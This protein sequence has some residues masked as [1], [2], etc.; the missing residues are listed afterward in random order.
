MRS[1]CTAP[2]LTAHQIWDSATRCTISNLQFQAVEAMDV[3]KT[4]HTEITDRISELVA[5]GKLP[6][7]VRDGTFTVEQ[8]K[9]PDHADLATNAA[10]VLAKPARMKPR[11]IAE[12]LVERLE[13]H[14]GIERAEI[15]G[16]GFVN[17]DLT[18]S[19]WQ[20]VFSNVLDSAANYGKSGVGQ[21]IKTNVEYVSANPTGP[22]HVGHCRGAVFGD[23]LANLLEFA[24][25][26]VT[27][28]F[29]VNDAGGQ[30]DVLAQSTFLRYRE[31][32]GEEIGAIP[33]G[34]YPGTYLIPVGQQLAETHGDA[35]IGMSEENW[36]PI[37]KRASIDAMLARIR[38]DL[39]TLDIEHDVFFSEASLTA[40]GEDAVAETIAELAGKGLIYE[41]R[42]EPPKGKLPDDWEDREQTLFKS[43]LYGDDVDRALVK[44]DG[45]YTYFAADLAYHRN[46][47][48]RGFDELI[49][50]LGADHGGY[51]K[52][53]TAAVRAL[54]DERTSLDCEIVQLVNL[55]RDGEPLKMSKRAGTFET[56]RDVVDQV[57][58]DPVRFMMLYR[59]N[60]APLEFDFAKVTEQSKDNPVFYV[61]M[62]H[63]RVCGVFREAALAFEDIG[64]DALSADNVNGIR[65]EADLTSIDDPG[66][67]ALAKSVALFPS[68]IESA[69]KRREPH[70]IAFFLYD[71]AT[72]LHQQ[73]SRGRTSP[74]LRFIQPEERGKTLA[75][76]TMLAAIRQVL[77]T[78]LSLLG[79]H[80]PQE[81]R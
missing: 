81:M 58:R 11:D 49:N 15:A 80:A 23:A 43:T 29:Y 73:Y 79:V 26:D 1:K 42:L 76:L 22:M 57:G 4:F 54:S 37:V 39:K 56:L 9:N 46:K 44:S 14:P 25:Y 77:H 60:D 51:I 59:K 48:R 16:P 45:S 38:D 47:I 35:L 53:I 66:E 63:A 3:F 72:A 13:C 5:E 12:L 31:A 20:A 6:P 32:L 55:M 30:I 64:A 8:P 34:L 27:R 67:L 41:G 33:E 40:N 28:E 70:R 36:L 74:H 68:L 10:M 71:L 50:V 21:G 69:A 2:N 52:R 19:V 62:A 78:G 18:Q 61:Q 7:E 24:S 65:M 75:R 17:L